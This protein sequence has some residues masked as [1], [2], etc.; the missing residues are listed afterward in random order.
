MHTWQSEQVV[1][2][3]CVWCSFIALSVAMST[4]DKDLPPNPLEDPSHLGPSQETVDAMVKKSLQ[5]QLAALTQQS[6]SKESGST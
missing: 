3:F 5:T 4:Q 6:S 2:E 1:V